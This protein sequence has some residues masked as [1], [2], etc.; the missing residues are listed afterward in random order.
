MFY[1]KLNFNF[2]FIFAKKAYVAV[3][4]EHSLILWYD[5][6]IFSYNM[7]IN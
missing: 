5:D 6:S 3:K 1:L 2:V 7:L 4:T